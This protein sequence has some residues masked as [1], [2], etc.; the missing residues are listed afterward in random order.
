MQWGLHIF[1][2]HSAEYMNT[3]GGRFCSQGNQHTYAE[4]MVVNKSQLAQQAK[5]GSL[6]AQACDPPVSPIVGFPVG[7]GFMR[8]QL[9]LKS[10]V[11]SSV[12]STLVSIRVPVVKPLVSISVD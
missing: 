7:E 1:R 2:G 6:G 5:S 4:I 11:S 3:W 10:L 12:P 9:L 8:V